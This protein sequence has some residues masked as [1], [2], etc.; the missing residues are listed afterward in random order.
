MSPTN[1][2]AKSPFI[3]CDKS[4]GR[5]SNNEWRECQRG[6]HVYNGVLEEGLFIEFE[7]DTDS[8]EK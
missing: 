5:T 8:E 1:F 4:Q 6:L 2:N 7:Q 3:S